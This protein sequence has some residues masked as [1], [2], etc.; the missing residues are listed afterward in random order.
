[1]EAAIRSFD[2]FAGMVCV[3]RVLYQF[4]E[5]TLG[6]WGGDRGCSL[7]LYN[8]KQVWTIV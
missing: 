1:M 8:S 3:P 5:N 2:F 4:N 7:F 6:L